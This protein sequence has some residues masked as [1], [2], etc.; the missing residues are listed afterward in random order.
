MAFQSWTVHDA[1]D[2]NPEG[3]ALA[4]SVAHRWQSGV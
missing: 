3:L 4:M 2:S 1:K